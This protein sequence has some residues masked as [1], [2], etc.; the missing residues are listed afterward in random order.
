[1]ILSD[2]LASCAGVVQYK[3]ALSSER[4]PPPAPHTDT[5]LPLQRKWASGLQFVED[6]PVPT[7]AVYVDPSSLDFLNFLGGTIQLFLLKILPA[8]QT[9]ISRQLLP[10]SFHRHTLPENGYW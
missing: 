4:P 9:S 8:G 10:L 1:M 7:E 2:Q 6:P 3:Q 5:V